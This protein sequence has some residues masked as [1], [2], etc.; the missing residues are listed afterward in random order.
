MNDETPD[1]DDSSELSG[2][3]LQAEKVRRLGL[4]DDLRSAGVEPYPY[5]F[6]RSHTLA[7]IRSTWGSL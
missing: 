5:R 2:S 6:D 7:E 3:G 1:S 4:L